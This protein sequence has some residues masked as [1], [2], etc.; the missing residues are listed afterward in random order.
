M[1]KFKILILFI[2]GFSLI[3]CTDKIDDIP[4]NFNGIET[5]CSD[6]IYVRQFVNNIYNFL[7]SGSLITLPSESKKRRRQSFL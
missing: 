1:K 6:S 4:L 3:K 2:I 5:I 7:P